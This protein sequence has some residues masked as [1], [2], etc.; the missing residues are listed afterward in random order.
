MRTAVRVGFVVLGAATA[1]YGAASLTGGWLG[2]PPW[3]DPRPAF[4]PPSSAGDQR[5]REEEAA[6]WAEHAASLPMSGGWNERT[7][8]PSRGAPTPPGGPQSNERQAKQPRPWWHKWTGLALCVFGIVEISVGAWPR[9][10]AE[11]EA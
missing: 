1:V 10:R 5:S 6:S 11:V 8:R 9:R 3:E 7:A 2:A 4:P